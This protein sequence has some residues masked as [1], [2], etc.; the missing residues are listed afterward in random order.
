M[1]TPLPPRVDYVQLVT[2]IG[3]VIAALT[4][5]V[6]AIG[7]LLS[8]IRGDRML[9]NQEQAKA[10]TEEVAL[11]L[12]DN[13]RKTEAVASTLEAITQPPGDI[14]PKRSTDIIPRSERE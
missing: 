14:V 5:L 12:D 3:S 2:A 11:K 7:V 8:K 10:K 1:D 9:Q 13:T 6:A 4:G